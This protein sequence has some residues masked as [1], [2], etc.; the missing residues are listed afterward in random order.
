[1]VRIGEAGSAVK[2]EALNTQQSR[3]LALYF[4]HVFDPCER[5]S[6]VEPLGRALCLAWLLSGRLRPYGDNW[7]HA[8]RFIVGEPGQ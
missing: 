2:M 1:M 5:D 8:Y 4:Q 3:I 6:R 7:C